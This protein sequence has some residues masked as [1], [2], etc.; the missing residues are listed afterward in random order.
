MKYYLKDD[1]NI[2]VIINNLLKLDNVYE[3]RNNEKL[4]M[5]GYKDSFDDNHESILIR[6]NTRQVVFGA[7]SNMFKD[8]LKDKVTVSFTD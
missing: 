7:T 8:K 1:Q 5:L 4:C 6:K 3:S 2:D